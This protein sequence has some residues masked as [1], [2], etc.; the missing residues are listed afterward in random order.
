MPADNDL[1]T[2]FSLG[3]Q[4]SKIGKQGSQLGAR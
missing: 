1:T 4:Q 3:L 2:A